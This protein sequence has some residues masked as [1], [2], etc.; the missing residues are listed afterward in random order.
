MSPTTKISIYEP[1]HQRL[2][3]EPS[4]TI[5]LTFAEIEAVVGRKLPASAH[6]FSAWWSNESS[7]KVGHTQ[8]KAWMNAGFRAHASIKERAVEFRRR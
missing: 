7:L 6:K 8:A 5:R 3:T 4:T 2:L 1:L